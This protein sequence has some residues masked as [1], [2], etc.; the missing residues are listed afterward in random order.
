MAPT[1]KI[2]EAIKEQLTKEDLLKLLSE[3]PQKQVRKKRDLDEEA[4]VK[5][6]ERM[7]QMRV[8]ALEKRQ[9][10]KK[11]KQDLEN[12]ARKIS[13]QD[14]REFEGLKPSQQNSREPSQKEANHE[15]F[16]KKYNSQFEKMNDTLSKLDSHLT[17]IKDLKKLKKEMIL[18]FGKQAML[19]KQKQESKQDSRELEGLKPSQ[20]NSRELEG[21]KPSQ[22][23]IKEPSQEVIQP[24]TSTQR[25]SREVE[26]VKPLNKPSLINS[27]LIIPK[28]NYKNIYHANKYF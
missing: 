23:N 15:L 7:A 22:Q 26:I 18:N 14:S 3:K 20:Q 6:N 9:S 27:S 8:L 5:M 16:E 28:I 1:K 2:K 19:D 12:P 17:E 24:V 10:L 4:K 11:E 25:S 21:L 13:Y